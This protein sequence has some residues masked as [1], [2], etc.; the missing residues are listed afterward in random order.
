MVKKLKTIAGGAGD[1]QFAQT[2]KDSAQQIWLAGLGAFVKAQAEGMK[3][4]NTLVKEGETLQSRTSKVASAK[5]AEAAAKASGTWDKL[6][7][8]FEDRVA[9]SL[10][11][12][13]VPTKKDI[14]TLS[15]R[16]AELTEVVQKLSGEKPAPRR[17]AK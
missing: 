14:E 13:G 15:K 4:F 1:K 16:V 8:V 17:R 7:Q 3:A 5:V 6:E 9:R 10:S 12:L 2:V 11:S